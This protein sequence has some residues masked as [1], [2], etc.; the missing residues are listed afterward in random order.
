MVLGEKMELAGTAAKCLTVLFLVGEFY[1][2]LI[3]IIMHC[4]KCCVILGPKIVTFLVVL[5]VNT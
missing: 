3:N 2:T 5:R 4:V 1:V